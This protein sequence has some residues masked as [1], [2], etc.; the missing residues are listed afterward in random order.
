M[1]HEGMCELGRK[2]HQ[3]QKLNFCCFGGGNQTRPVCSTT[4]GT[5]ETARGVKLKSWVDGPN[6]LAKPAGFPNPTSE[7]TRGNMCLTAWESE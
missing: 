3:S 5:L 1:I 7:L 4:R 6:Q 2:V